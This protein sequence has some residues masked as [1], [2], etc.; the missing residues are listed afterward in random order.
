MEFMVA[1]P[2]LGILSETSRV[3]G[4]GEAVAA[5]FF[6]RDGK[7]FRPKLLPGRV[8]VTYTGVNRY[9]ISLNYRNLA[10]NLF[11]VFIFIESLYMIYGYCTC[12]IRFVMRNC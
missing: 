4:F 12:L 5:F 11:W 7:L 2:D 1:G 6:N 8:D 10:Y 9:Q 3:A